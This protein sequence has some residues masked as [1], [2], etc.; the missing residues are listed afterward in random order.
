MVYFHCSA[1]KMRVVLICSTYMKEEDHTFLPDVFL[2][3]SSRRR[4]LASGCVPPSLQFFWSRRHYCL[5]TESRILSVWKLWQMCIHSRKKPV[6]CSCKMS[7]VL[8][9][10]KVRV[11]QR[12]WCA[13]H[14]DQKSSICNFLVQMSVLLINKF[15]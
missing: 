15:K 14:W 3:N 9:A 10:F 6:W 11:F 4:W 12:N 5:E 2:I 1:E 8:V 7:E 13:D